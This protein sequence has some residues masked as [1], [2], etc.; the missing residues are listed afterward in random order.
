MMEVQI[1]EYFQQVREQGLSSATRRILLRNLIDSYAGICASLQDL[2]MLQRFKRYAASTPDPQ[3]VFVW[4]TGQRVSPVHAVFLNSILG[5]RSDLVN[6]YLA[7]NHMGGNHPSDNVSL[8]LTLAGRKNLNGKDFL[9]AMHLAYVFS[10][11]FS[12]YYDPEEGGFDH[13]AAAGLY[14]ALICG[15]VLGLDTKQ[16]IQV[17]RIAGAMG[18]NTNQA[19]EGQVT[20]WKHCTYASCA[21]HGLS[22]AIMADAG[23]EGPVDIYCGQAGINRF[24]PHSDSFMAA[25]PDLGRIVFKRWQALVFCQTAIDAALELH[26]RL[27]ALETAQVQRVQLWTYQMALVQAGTA[28]AMRPVSRAGRTHSLA[29]CV[30]AALLLGTIEYASFSDVVAQR[31]DL[32]AL[33]AKLELHEDAGM[34]AAYPESTPCRLRITVADGSGFETRLEVP[35]GDPRAPLED[36]EIAAKAVAYLREL[37]TQEQAE[38]TVHRLWH[39]DGADDLDWLLQPLIREV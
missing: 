7:P 6:T 33:M 22:A 29:Y 32:Q 8:L 15:H 37:V 5:R 9:E 34:T 10:C 25:R 26:A 35:K 16:L 20:D 38:A 11:A 31:A 28:E 39:V 13:D 24:L 1:A 2:P 19:G 14:T 23:F 36:E 27:A 4:G 17:Q 3:G 18:L 21:M 12:D 30:A